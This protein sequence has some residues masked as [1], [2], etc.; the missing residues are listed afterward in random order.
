MNRQDGLHDARIGDD[1]ADPPTEHV[2]DLARGLDGD[3]AITNV[4]ERGQADV[5]P[6]VVDEVLVGFVDDDEQ[7]VR[8]RRLGDRLQIGAAEH[9]AGG[10]VRVA[11]EENP[12]TRGHPVA[13]R[14]DVEGEA[15]AAG[16]GEADRRAMRD[17]HHGLEAE[18]ARIG[19]EHFVAGF[20]E[21]EESREQ[22]FHSA[23][24]TP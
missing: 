7:V 16:E 14:V 8:P 4:F 9:D 1:P 5:L 10:V 20:D 2:V 18:P 23:R 6:S 21:R 22:P 11:Q 24:G 19:Q 3:G 13:Q 17:P 12:G 15:V